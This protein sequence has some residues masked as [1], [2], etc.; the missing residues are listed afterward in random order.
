LGI[1]VVGHFSR[2]SPW[3]G[4]HILIQ[5]LNHC[6]DDMI[7]F[8]VGDALFGE[9]EYIQQLHQQVTELELGD[10]FAF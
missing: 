7:A 5:A 4:Q 6:S 10:R 9:Q 8:F 2:L 3:K 1:L